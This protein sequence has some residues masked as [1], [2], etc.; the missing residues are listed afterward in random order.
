MLVEV[1]LEMITSGPPPVYLV[2]DHKMRGAGGRAGSLSQMA[3]LLAVLFH[4]YYQKPISHAG[5]RPV[6]GPL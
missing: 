2:I 1:V 3:V 5:L 4:A 6:Y